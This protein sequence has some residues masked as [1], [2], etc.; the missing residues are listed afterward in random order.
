MHDP[1]I[2]E[3]RTPAPEG[4]QNELSVALRLDFHEVENISSPPTGNISG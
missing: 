1:E 3:D 4:F 2:G